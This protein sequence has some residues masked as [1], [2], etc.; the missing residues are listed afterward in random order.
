MK[1]ATGVCPALCLVAYSIFLA[2]DAV[3]SGGCWVGDGLIIRLASQLS[4]WHGVVSSLVTCAFKVSWLHSSSA[5][6]ASNSPLA[7]TNISRLVM[8]RFPHD[9]R[10]TTMCFLAR[11]LRYT[12]FRSTDTNFG[13]FD[14]IMCTCIWYMYVQNKLLSRKVGGVVVRN[15]PPYRRA[16]S[17]TRRGSL[18]SDQS[19]PPAFSFGRGLTGLRSERMHRHVRVL[20]QPGP[21]RSSIKQADGVKPVCC[22][23]ETAQQH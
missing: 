12:I 17:L 9:V 15:P 18:A 10:Y 16:G 22:S 14:I 1:R 21:L 3:C 20:H 2:S 11:Y 19:Q 23:S 13:T 8:L 6:L 4:G 7:S 5:D